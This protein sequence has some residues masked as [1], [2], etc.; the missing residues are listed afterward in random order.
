MVEIEEEKYEVEEDKNKE[1]EFVENEKLE[2]EELEKKEREEKKKKNQKEKEKM[3]INLVQRL[4][5]L[6]V[7][8]KKDNARNYVRFLDILSRFQINIP[9]SE[10]LE[11]MPT[12][13]KF[14]KEILTNKMRYMDKETINLNVSCS[15]IIQRTLPQKETDPG[16][17]T[18][19]ITI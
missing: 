5:Y 14:M 6:H 17:V 3:K 13:A 12:Y 19:P 7:P 10:A 15:A 18:L 11:Q 16:R 4:S 8:S 1:E 2:K 9:F